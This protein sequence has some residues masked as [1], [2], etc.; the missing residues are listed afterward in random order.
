MEKNGFV[1]SLNLHKMQSHSK[2]RRCNGRQKMF[3]KQVPDD[4]MAEKCHLAC[5]RLS[6]A[7]P[8]QNPNSHSRFL[9][10]T[11][12][13]IGPLRMEQSLGACLEKLS[14][15]RNN[16]TNLNP[17]T[18]LVQ[19]CHLITTCCHIH[20]TTLESSS[21][22]AQRFESRLQTSYTFPPEDVSVYVLN[23]GTFSC[24]VVVQ[25]LKLIE[26]GKPYNGRVYSVY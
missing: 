2:S 6:L 26:I 14:N 1:V 8:L 12:H 16:C 21:I 10:L 7:N 24:V 11:L 22:F 9:S 13:T 15:L 23:T 3:S 25:I 5:G 18:P 4:N 20:F 19:I 17:H